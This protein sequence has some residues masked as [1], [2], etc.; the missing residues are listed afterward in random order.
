[1]AVVYLGRRLGPPIAEDDEEFVALK[2]IRDELSYNQD[3]VAMFLDEVKIVSALRNPSIVRLLEFGQEGQRLYCALELVMGQSLWRVWDACRMRKSRLRYDW[4]AYVGA[5]TAEGLHVAH[6]LRDGHGNQVGFVH[7][8][9]SPSNILISYDGR[10]K[11]IDFGLAKSHQRLSRTTAGVVKGKYAYMAPEQAQSSSIDRRADIFALGVTLWELS[12]DKRLFKRKNDIDTLIAV[13]DAV[14]PDPCTFV[15]GYPRPLWRVLR[16]AMRKE[17]AKRYAN[18]LEMARDLDECSKLEGRKL[19]QKDVGEI[20]HALFAFEA[21]Q[22][23]T[24]LDQAAVSVD[25]EDLS[26]RTS[27]SRLHAAPGIAPDEWKRQLPAGLLNER[28]PP[29]KTR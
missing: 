25:S 13:A 1:M 26:E 7:R 27:V 24:L 6:E 15:M 16:R 11:I 20:M 10:I 29:P 18:A 17:P 12:C 9:V 8:D 3:F 22:D 2:V 4:L 14:V 19:G 5:R 28:R 23:R 21:Q